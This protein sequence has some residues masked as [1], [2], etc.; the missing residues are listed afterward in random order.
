MMSG[1]GKNSMEASLEKVRNMDIF[2][3]D[4]EISLDRQRETSLKASADEYER[5]KKNRDIW[6][7]RISNFL[8]NDVNLVKNL[9]RNKTLKQI[10]EDYETLTYY[11]PEEKPKVARERK[12]MDRT[13][14]ILFWFSV[15]LAI[16]AVAS[17]LFKMKV[18]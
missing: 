13:S 4:D 2:S 7:E 3:E 18:V 12:V 16:V 6:A 5:I 10:E 17:V 8:E 15:S 1:P 14:H 11:L 9:I